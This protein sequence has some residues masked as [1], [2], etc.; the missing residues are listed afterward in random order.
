MAE[1]ALDFFLYFVNFDKW[2]SKLPDIINDRIYC[3]AT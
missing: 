3:D 2:Q 1:K